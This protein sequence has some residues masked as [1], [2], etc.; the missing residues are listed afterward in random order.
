MLKKK[1]ISNTMKTSVL[2]PDGESHLLIYLINCLSQTSGIS[3]FVMSSSK[4]NPVRFSRHISKFV[5]YPKTEDDRGWV[6]N[7]NEVVKKYHIDLIMPIFE[8]GIHRILKNKK[9]LDQS[10]SLVLLPDIKAFDIAINKWKLAS[11][12]EENNIPVPQS[13]LY[14]P[15]QK[16]D[17][18]FFTKIEFPVIVK[19]LEGFGGGMGIEVFTNQKDI[20][21]YLD[22]LT[23]YPVIIQEFIKGYDIDCSILA[24][25]GKIVAH[26][27]QKGFLKGESPY[28]PQVGISFTDNVQLLKVVE[29]LIDSLQWD[30][31]AHLDLRYDQEKKTYKVI[32]LN[33]RFWGSMDASCLMGV[34]FPHLL[35]LKSLGHS[36]D[37]QIYKH[38]DY[39]NLKG[40]VKMIKKD[41]LFI[42]KRKLIMN[43]SQFRFVVYDPAPTIY[44]YFDRTKNLLLRSIGKK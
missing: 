41:F 14:A 7:I 29:K 15:K 6:H 12:C 38:E 19:P 2:I 16:I 33:P 25:N 18:G 8:K 39:Y 9:Y 28:A 13:F 20:A 17:N 42:T 36:F 23:D 37:D 35:I 3:V 43:N 11:F 30:G 26:T 32:E 27:I 10:D 5:H 34:N 40:L 24:I 44:K 1:V 21:Q 4:W 22:K 31:V